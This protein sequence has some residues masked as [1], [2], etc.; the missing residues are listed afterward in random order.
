MDRMIIRPESPADERA[1]TAL[2]QRAFAT[3]PHASL[4]EQF[5]V[6]ALRRLGALTLSLVAEA[7]GS[8]VGQVAFSPVDLGDGT[9]GWLGLGPLAVEPA[10]QRQGIGG[11]LVRAGLERLRG[12]AAGCVVL[13]DPG[14]YGRFGFRA[15]PGL[16]YPG[17]PP[18]YFMALAWAGPAP[19]GVV[20][21]SP[22]FEAVA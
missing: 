4:T 2:T 18:E 1:I 17:P 9:P 8:V 12:T 20:S 7:Q 22:A 21:F 16:V 15:V 3:A 14:Y 11:A 5:I 10:W 13:G 19:V 6:P